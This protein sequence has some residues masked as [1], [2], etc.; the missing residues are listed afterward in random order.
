MFRI[1]P[2]QCYKILRVLR[3]DA[4][5]FNTG[6]EYVDV[7]MLLYFRHDGSQASNNPGKQVKDR[8]GARVPLTEAKTKKTRR[9]VASEFFSRV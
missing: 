4:L 7:G 2:N 1:S 3:H 6:T 8:G 5:G 9:G